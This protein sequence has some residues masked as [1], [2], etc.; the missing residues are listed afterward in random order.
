MSGVHKRGGM[1]SAMVFLC[2]VM[3]A[4]LVVFPGFLA[5]MSTLTP[6]WT[7]RFGFPPL[8]LSATQSGAVAAISMTTVVLLIWLTTGTRREGSAKRLAR[9]VLCV[10]VL[11]GAV[12]NLLT[13]G[14]VDRSEAYRLRIASAPTLAELIVN[15]PDTYPAADALLWLRQHAAGARIS[16]SEPDLRSAGL[17][18]RRLQGISHLVVRDKATSNV[19]PDVRVVGRE[20]VRFHVPD[21]PRQLLIDVRQA[22]PGARLCAIPAADNLMIIAADDVPGCEAPE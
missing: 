16:A 14:I 7:S 11:C 20:F 10:A 5:L 17:A 22:R 9:V 2:Q 4:V 21:A 13:L 3:L 1:A 18:A 19:S 6:Q 8:G 15:M 12:F